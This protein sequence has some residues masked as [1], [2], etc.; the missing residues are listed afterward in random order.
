MYLVNLWC[1]KLCQFKIFHNTSKTVLFLFKH[2]LVKQFQ[3]N[4]MTHSYQTR[5]GPLRPQP[6]ARGR[7]LR[8]AQHPPRP[9][10]RPR[11]LP[12]RVLRGFV[13]EADGAAVGRQE[14]AARV[15]GRAAG[16]GRGRG[17]HGVEDDEEQG[18]QRHGAGAG[19]L[20]QVR[21]MFF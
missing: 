10:G 17:A 16:P 5:V 4:Q 20:H 2:S 8:E 19:G 15:R 6:G 11:L 13:H 21:V 18:L 1:Q 3:F 12:G 7:R 14:Q 9:G